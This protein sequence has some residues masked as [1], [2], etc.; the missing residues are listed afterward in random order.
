M[1]LRVIESKE[2]L[3]KALLER[4]PLRLLCFVVIGNLVIGAAPR[5]RKQGVPLWGL[6]RTRSASLAV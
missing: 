5:H 3:Y 4:A 1:P 6:I 2:R